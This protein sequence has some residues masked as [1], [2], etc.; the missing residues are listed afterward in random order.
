M[1]EIIPNYRLDLQG[2]PCPYPAIRTL[3]V[4]PELK[5]GEILEVLSDCPQSINNIPIDIKNY[6]Y[7]MLKIE[8]LGAT[9]RY[10]IKK[11]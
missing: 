1:Q 8:Q 6:G 2:E 7:E 11:P 4:L 10:L 5:K 9:I 3:E